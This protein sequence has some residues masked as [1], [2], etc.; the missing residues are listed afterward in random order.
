[1]LRVKGTLGRG[2]GYANPGYGGPGYPG[3][4]NPGYGG[5][6]A[7]PEFSFSCDV[8]YNGYVQ[9]VRVESLYRNY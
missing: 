6:Y 4:G 7:R 2:G 3:Y 5:G 8:G 1:V 9:S